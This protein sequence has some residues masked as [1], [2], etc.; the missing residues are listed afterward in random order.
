[1]NILIISDYDKLALNLNSGFKAQGH[2][3]KLLTTR[4]LD[5]DDSINVSLFQSNKIIWFK[6]AIR[7]FLYR[8]ILLRIRNESY[9]QDISE[10]SSYYSIKRFKRRIGIKPDVIIVLFDYRIIT[11]KS[12]A[13]L[14]KWAKAKIYWLMVDMKPF[15]GG[16][17][18]SSGCK[19]YETDCQ[20][21]PSIGNPFFKDFSNK[22]LL[23][24]K[25]IYENIEIE[26]IA[27]STFQLAQANKSILFNNTKKHML[28]FPSDNQIFN[29][30]DQKTARN[31]LRLPLNKKIIMFGATKITESRK[32]YSYLI[33]SLELFIRLYSSDNL[34][35]LIVG[36]NHQERLNELNI[37][38]INL[39]F[40]D[41]Q[42]LAL[43]YQST[44]V[45]VCP[46]I[47]DSGPVMVTQSLLCGTPVVAFDTGVSKDLVINNKTGY[48]AELKNPT[49]LCMGI[50]RILDM[51]LSEKAVMLKNC[52]NI[53]KK[54][55]FFDF[56]NSL[57]N[58]I[59]TNEN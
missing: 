38:T 55:N 15:T 23:A 33:Q 16:C 11:A 30:K 54:L 42:K 8:K 4:H 47:E 32:G 6:N 27:G 35:L 58:I 36:V 45:F 26:I 18:Y 10:N 39:G 1:M 2:H 43:A 49:D 12:I 52:I 53:S 19:K 41:Y 20:D 37:E 22:Q 56:C 24:K 29:Y 44:D 25:K 40:V 59:L 34:L 7:S 5:D 13:E 46:T 14:Q 57:N 17:S 3:S 50:K 48:L 9:Y 31:E 51:N 28:I 21:C